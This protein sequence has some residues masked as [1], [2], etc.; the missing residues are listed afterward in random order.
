MEIWFYHLQR[1]PLERVLPN[2]LEKSLERGWRAVVQATSEERLNALDH[3]LWTYADESFLAHGLAR[4][5]DATMQPVYLTLGAENPNGAKIRIFVE[6]ANVQDVVAADAS[7]YE[8]AILMF[9]GND[10]DQLG[11]ARA[12]WKALKD[13]GFAVA[14]WQQGENG[15]WEKKA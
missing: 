12:Q 15:R 4:D 3:L 14:Y 8:R 13:A 6:A 11:N 2:L 10:P 9:D 5:G 1:H 7:A